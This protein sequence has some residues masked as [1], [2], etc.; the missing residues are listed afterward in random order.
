MGGIKFN[1]LYDIDKVQLLLTYNEPQNTQKQ[2]VFE[3]YFAAFKGYALS[4]LKIL[5]FPVCAI[6]GM[7]CCIFVID[8]IK[9]PVTNAVMV[10]VNG[11]FD[12][13]SPDA[14]LF[15]DSSD[16]SFVSKLLRIYDEVDLNFENFS[17]IV[18]YDEIDETPDG[19]VY[20]AYS[21]VKVL[22]P[23]DAIVNSI[24]K[25]D[26]ET[27]LSLKIDEKTF[28]V[29]S[30]KIIFGLQEGSLVAR[31]SIIGVNCGDSYPITFKVYKNGKLVQ[32]LLTEFEWI[33]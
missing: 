19:L 1:M 20:T 29:I 4:F 5:Y 15:A 8:T 25:V 6:A 3:K 28:A 21:V 13:L 10:Y 23:C 32:N 7:L 12:F 24:D 31:G 30:G 11:F 22:A 17:H 16:I 18:A 9:T 2:T 26:G 14:N 27:I 33:N